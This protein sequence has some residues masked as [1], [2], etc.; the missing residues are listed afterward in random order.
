M[1]PIKQIKDWTW[2]AVTDEKKKIDIVL[3]ASIVDY[4]SEDLSIMNLAE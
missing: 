3:N 1:P 4:G 2:F